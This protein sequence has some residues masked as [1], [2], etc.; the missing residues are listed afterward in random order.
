[1]NSYGTKKSKRRCGIPNLRFRKRESATTMP[2]T[3]VHSIRRILCPVDFDEPIAEANAFAS[4]LARTFD[5]TLCYLHCAV[6]DVLFGKN[7]FTELKREEHELLQELKSIRPACTGVRA[8]YEV[9]FGLP[10]D[11]IVR[12]ASQYD[13]DI[14][15]IGTHGRKG[16][17]RLFRGSVAEQ[18]IR[19]ADCPVVA[20]KNDA[21][22]PTPLP[23]SV[24]KGAAVD[25]VRE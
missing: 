21:F 22:V 5:A 18:V 16:L 14:I 17:G 25:E 10:A 20:I 11:T 15:V 1:M 23:G 2:H 6:P 24:A 7:E 3:P 4:M 12:H 9:E 8:V 19:N 13:F